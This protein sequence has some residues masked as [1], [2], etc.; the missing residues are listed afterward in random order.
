M[1]HLR[2]LFL[3]VPMVVLSACSSEPPVG[4]AK[5]KV[6]A[7]TTPW[8]FGGT[9]VG[10][11]I[12]K[13]FTLQNNGRIPVQAWVESIPDPYDF[14]FTE[15]KPLVIPASG[16]VEVTG[17]FDPEEV[18]RFDGSVVWRTIGALDDR[19][20]VRVHGEG[21]TREVEFPTVLNFGVV[22]VGQQRTMALPVRSLSG[23]RTQ[24]VGQLIGDESAFSP[25]DW[26][27]D[28]EAE[29]ERIVDITFHP[30]S[31]GG[32]SARY[33][34]VT[35]PGCEKTLTVTGHGGAE[36]LH[37]R[38]QMLPF[39][40]ITPGK[41]A[42]VELRL[43]NRG[44]LPVPIRRAEFVAGSDPAFT[45][46][47]T[48]VPAVVAEDG[49]HTLWVSFE[50]SVDVEEL[51]EKRGTLRFL[52][53]DDE[54][55]VDI[56]LIGFVGGPDLRVEPL[57]VDFG[58]QPLGVTTKRKVSLINEGNLAPVKILEVFIEG[59]GRSAFSR[60][61]PGS[62]VT[63]TTVPAVVEISYRADQVGI[64]DAFLVIRSDD[65]DTK[66]LRI[67]LRGEGASLGPC[68][69]VVDPPQV[70]F[71]LVGPHQTRERGVSIQH[72]GSSDCAVW[73]FRMASN[74]SR[75]FSVSGAPVGS[76][77][78]R[79]GEV[80]ELATHFDV[81]AATS[82]SRVS[83]MVL[84]SHSGEG[85]APWEI[86]LDGLPSSLELRVFPESVDF[87]R[88]L[89]DETVSKA[90]Y[91]LNSGASVHVDRLEIPGPEGMFRIESPAT[92]GLPALSTV[93]GALG[94][95]ARAPLLVSA[96]GVSPGKQNSDLKI[97]L[98]GYAEP[99]LVPVHAE[100]DPDSCESD[101]G[102]AT[103]ICGP[104]ESIRVNKAHVLL[105]MGRT[106]TGE[107]TGCDWTVLRA[108]TDSKARPAM[109]GRCLTTFIPD[110][111][112]EYTLEM[113][114]SGGVGAGDRCQM[115]V[116]AE[117]PPG[118]WVETV[119]DPS[120]NVSLFLLHPDAGNPLNNVSWNH[121]NL[122]CRS[123][124]CGGA[125]FPDWDIPGP[126]GNPVME[127]VGNW[128]DP[129]TNIFIATPTPGIQYSVGVHHLQGGGS[130]WVKARVFCDGSPVAAENVSLTLN[131]EFVYLGD[132]HFNGSEG[133]VWTSVESRW[134]R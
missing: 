4:D 79:P 7:M 129:L 97:W 102:P 22:P 45:T 10:D 95:G 103:A 85:T 100:V 106:S 87:G 89:L 24:I 90:M 67:P 77:V 42:T 38:P 93:P 120:S 115:K 21:L 74:G 125:G 32:H 29:E 69:L 133:C 117:P 94:A 72:R 70:H 123:G 34:V 132:I 41:S 31:V 49:H 80:I 116:A 26:S 6:V 27:F 9:L 71:G 99:L 19:L 47:H 121:F 76:R 8:E 40:V 64:H 23:S 50:P 127:R 54:W 126:A 35:C 28:L 108:P 124:N 112:G 78:L 39:G 101:C 57:S 113:A 134:I 36:R 61:G 46:D 52:G 59:D 44:F 11:R 114:V 96:E 51:G 81:E 5:G 2:W 118:L 3:L 20:I 68:E 98:R 105:G 1:R 107:E 55:L 63:L 17:I 130:A 119:W 110:L 16:T 43:E 33:T 13:T 14:G 111:V 18:G 91:V 131:R 37:G 92:G 84:F 15:A 53:D 48:R 122:V 62:N 88:F 60:T 104:D 56:P 65:D 128:L 25:A 86:P 82:Q 109:A 66:E 12:E 30:P 73:D 83:S 75:L 58:I